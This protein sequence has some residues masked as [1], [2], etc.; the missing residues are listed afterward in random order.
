M[1]VVIVV[2]LS[3]RLL[4]HTLIHK[5]EACLAAIQHLV[6][7]GYLSFDRMAEGWLLV[8]R[9]WLSPL[10]VEDD[11]F[12]FTFIVLAIRVELGLG[13]GLHFLE[14]EFLVVGMWFSGLISV[15]MFEFSIHIHQQ[16]VH[17]SASI[18]I[19]L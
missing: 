14:F 10:A 6:D 7:R 13:Y 2:G 3:I 1:V 9:V 5:R 12:F 4:V 17:L 19:L 18:V 16:L 8:D 15:E 11:L